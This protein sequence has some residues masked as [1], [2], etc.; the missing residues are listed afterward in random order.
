MVADSLSTSS[1][2]GELRSDHPGDEPPLRAP[3]PPRPLH[4]EERHRHRYPWALLLAIGLVGV[5]ELVVRRVDSRSLIL[6][7]DDSDQARAVRD[8]IS[9]DEP[10][11]IAFVGSSMMYQGINGPDL[12]AKLSKQLDRDVIVRNEAI[13]GGRIDLFAATVRHL[14]RQEHKPKLI[15][16][17]TSMRDLREYDLDF[18]RLAMFWTFGDLAHNLRAHGLRQ[19]TH[20][21]VVIRNEIEPHFSL[22]KYRTGI[23]NRLKQAFVDIETEPLPARGDVPPQHSGPRRDTVLT[24]DEFKSSSNKRRMT[25]AYRIDLPPEPQAKFVACVDDI[26]AECRSAGVE[27][28]FLDLPISEPMQG[29]LI[30]ADKKRKTDQIEPKYRETMKARCEAGGVPF[31]TSEALG[32]SWNLTDFYDSQHLNYAGAVKLGDALLPRLVEGLRR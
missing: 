14:L 27:V 5:V 24:M 10:I 21:P 16:V 23:S 1:F 6:T 8:Q 7:R 4:R 22:L 11:D 29:L 30:H 25:Q 2:K 13:R 15:V 9:L 19:R 12:Q 32:L 17:G 28:I 26:I 31:V 3:P 18:E 20:L